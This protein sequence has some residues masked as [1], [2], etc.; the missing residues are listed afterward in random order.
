MKGAQEERQRIVRDL[1]DDVAGKLLAMKLM[2]PSTRYANLADDALKALRSVIYSLDRPRGMN[3]QEACMR[4]LGSVR[5]RCEARN[6]VLEFSLQD[7]L[8]HFMLTP[9]QMLNYERIIYEGVT[10][11]IVHSTAEKI[12]ID[13]YLHENELVVKLVNDGN[14]GEEREHSGHG[15]GLMNIAQRMS[16]MGGRMK[17]S[18][19]RAKG[20]FRLFCANPI[21]EEYAENTSS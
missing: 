13:L 2:S 19:D 7:E 3:L 4:W 18:D 21:K 8:E 15:I 1:H 5:E 14:L 10:N 9:R 17:Y 12:S 6:I 16:E 20:E 11:A